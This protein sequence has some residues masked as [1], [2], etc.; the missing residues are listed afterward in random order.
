MGD[1]L[2]TRF[3]IDLTGR[4]LTTGWMP[5]RSARVICQSDEDWLEF[6]LD[7]ERFQPWTEIIQGDVL[8]DFLRM[9]PAN[10]KQVEDFVLKFGPLGIAMASFDVGKL[11]GRVPLQQI[12]NRHFQI[13]TIVN[14]RTAFIAGDRDGIRHWAGEYLAGVGPFTMN[15]TAWQA[16]RSEAEQLGTIGEHTMNR[17]PF[18]RVI[19]IAKSLLSDLIPDHVMVAMKPVWNGNS[20]I[21]K[22]DEE[23]RFYILTDALRWTLWHQSEATS[24]KLCR[25]WAPNHTKCL[26]YYVPGRQDPD[27]CST[28]CT[29]HAR[30]IARRSAATKR[31]EAIA[32]DVLRK[33]RGRCAREQ[34]T[35][36][37]LPQ[38][39]K[40]LA[41]D[42]ITR[43]WLSR[44]I[45]SLKS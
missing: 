20:G 40:R 12:R 30:T 41:P 42:R 18:A 25:N 35:L 19:E 22:L 45:R 3:R 29:K 14:L 15:M 6:T 21:G 8:T 38:I 36:K 2:T 44:F 24:I 11:R 43:N 27:Y 4:R 17:I 37:A 39:N 28:A 1:E 16:L 33:F 9:D 32:A 13:T 10:K 31:Q 34:L 5:A 23:F 7:N 26:K